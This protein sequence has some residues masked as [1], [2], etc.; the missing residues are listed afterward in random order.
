MNER[1]ENENKTIDQHAVEQASEQ[2]EK[3]VW[4]V[5]SV[6]TMDIKE[7]AAIVDS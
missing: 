1:T 7:T 3:A 6:R 4:S 5:P 2:A